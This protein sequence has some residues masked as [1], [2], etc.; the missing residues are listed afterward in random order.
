MLNL[1]GVVEHDG[2]L[3]RNCIDQSIGKSKQA[4][5]LR[6]KGYSNGEHGEH[7]TLYRQY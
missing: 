6:Y 4:A 1:L 7:K 5:K 2:I 3:S